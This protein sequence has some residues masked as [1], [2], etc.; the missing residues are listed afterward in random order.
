MREMAHCLG[1]GLGLEVVLTL[2]HFMLSRHS[3]FK[4]GLVR[5]LDPCISH[6]KPFSQ[7]Y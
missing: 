6:T 5:L 1:K 3:H 7:V 2:C 4:S